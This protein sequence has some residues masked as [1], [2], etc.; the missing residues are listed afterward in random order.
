MRI[1]VKY[2]INGKIRFISHLDLMRAFFRACIRKD[3]PVAISQG[4]SPHLK[5]SFGP[6]L[7]VGMT[8]SDEYLDMHMVKPVDP[9]WIKTNLQEGL[10]EGLRIEEVYEVPKDELSLSMSMNRAVYKIKVPEDVRG[11]TSHI[12]VRGCTSHIDGEYLVI[13]V[14]IGQ[15]GNVK[16]VDVLTGLWPELGLDELKLWLIHREK[17]YN[18][19]NPD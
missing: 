4:F 6:P 15:N 1:R 5:I 8:S 14:P 13:D 19:R 16:P 12:C 7:S 9:A 2:S 17:L 3:I 11:A 10:P 18:E